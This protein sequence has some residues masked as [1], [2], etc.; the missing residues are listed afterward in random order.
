MFNYNAEENTFSI[1]FDMDGLSE[2]VACAVDEVIENFF[3]E[4][5]VRFIDSKEYN[6]LFNTLLD[7]IRR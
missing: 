3:G 7:S 1:S 6:T 4:T 5:A 2:D